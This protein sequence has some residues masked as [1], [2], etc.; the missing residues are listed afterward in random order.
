[1]RA[2]WMKWECN[3]CSGHIG[4]S[5]MGVVVGTAVSI[6]T[7]GKHQCEW[8]MYGKHKWVNVFVAAIC[9]CYIGWYL[10]SIV[11]ICKDLS[12]SI[13]YISAMG[14]Q[15]SY[16]PV[17]DDGF[18]LWLI[19]PVLA[20]D[21]PLDYFD[22]G[23]NIL[24]CRK[25]NGY[26]IE[27]PATSEKQTQPQP[28]PT[29]PMCVSVCVCNRTSFCDMNKKFLVQQLFVETISILHYK[30]RKYFV[31]H[32]VYTLIN[33]ICTSALPPPPFFFLKESIGVIKLLTCL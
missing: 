14:G 27:T 17:R 3:S 2:K 33:T 22:W 7:Q 11:R 5:W 4:K 24:F 6:V 30:W 21:S 23:M 28:T 13:W 18:F 10:P 16:R 12:L 1:M 20:L 26:R 15:W 8:M 32:I 19:S 9:Y 29:N 25:Q 31:S